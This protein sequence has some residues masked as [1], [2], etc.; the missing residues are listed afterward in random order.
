MQSTIHLV[1]PISDDDLVRFSREK[2]SAL[3][4]EPSGENTDPSGNV[5]PAFESKETPP[6]R[7]A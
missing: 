2:R 5:K 6:Y 4:H 1:H 3:I 7:L